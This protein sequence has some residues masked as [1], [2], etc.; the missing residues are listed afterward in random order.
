DG[1]AAAVD[2][3]ADNQVHLSGSSA[4]GRRIPATIEFWKVVPVKDTYWLTSS[5][6]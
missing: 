1:I 6:G 3:G 5:T 2:F 4:D